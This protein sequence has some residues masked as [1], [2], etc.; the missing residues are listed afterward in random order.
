[1][2]KIARKPSTDPV[3]EKL[4]QDK[5]TWNTKVTVFI[6][7]LIHLKKTMNGWASKFNKQKSR[8]TE[9]IPADPVTIIGS[10]ASDFQQMAT[11]ANK[12]VEQQ[13]QYSKNRRQKTS[14]TTP[15]LSKQL[16]LFN[17]LVES[18][19]YS[20]AS[21]PISRFFTRLLNP[22]IGWGEAARIRKY[23]MSLLDGAV[24]LYR[25]LEYLQKVIMGSRQRTFNGFFS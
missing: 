10:L 18:K 5:A 23:R 21:N 7:D 17:S 24:E 20:E 3:Q 11:D 6:N 16:S 9:P 15:D 14:P 19:L 12:I 22:G 25:S 13:I 4:R 8:I 2:F 1:M